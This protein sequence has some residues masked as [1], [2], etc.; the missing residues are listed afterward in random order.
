M[1]PK[2]DYSGSNPIL[3]SECFTFLVLNNPPL[4]ICFMC[5][6][7]PLKNRP[8]YYL[9]RITNLQFHSH[10]HWFAAEI[11]HPFHLSH[12]L[13]LTLKNPD[14]GDG[15]S[16]SEESY[17]KYDCC[18]KRLGEYSYHCSIC[19]Y[20][21][22]TTCTSVPL[23]LTIT[24]LKR[25]DHTLTLFPGHIP[26]PCKACG[27]SLGKIDDHVYTCHPCSYMVHKTCIYLPRVIKITRHAH[28][29]VHSSSLHSGELLCGVCRHT[30]D[31]SY[32][33]YS[34]T[35]KC[36]YAVHSKCAT[37][38]DVWDGKDL[39]EVPEEPDEDVAPFVMIDEKTIQHFSHEHWLKLHRNDK[40]NDHENKFCQACTLP[41]KISDG[42]Y[43]CMQ[44]DFV[45]DE[46]CAC[47]PRKNSHPVHKHPLT[48]LNIFPP[49]RSDLWFEMFPKGYFT[50]LGCG[51]E[52]C[53]FLYKCGEEDCT[54][55]LDVRCAY[56]PDPFIHGCHPHDHPLFFNLT[57]GNCM[58]CGND[59]CANYALECI[60]CKFFLGLYCATI[61][62]VAHYK[63]H[64]NPLTLCYGEEKTTVLQ[65]W[66]EVCESK[67]DSKT[68][69][70]ACG[71]CSLTL[72]IKCLLGAKS[73][74]KPN[75]H[76][77]TLRGEVEVTSNNGNSRP[78]CDQCD[79]R[80]ID[81][82]TY[83]LEDKYCCSVACVNISED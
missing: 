10:C 4:S 12:P 48:L 45:L 7:G 6:K 35:K 50:C 81:T 22:C 26:L 43:S 3:P 77:K 64:E 75:H 63:Y 15:V 19:D 72:H 20:S 29:L 2:Y 71:C 30:I 53:G 59:I 47:L 33:Q 14:S 62:S 49:K 31:V 78:L 25:H 17:E 27:T 24:H 16:V 28:R 74:M 76:I 83:K 70:Y 42:F 9:C 46:I 51:R 32:G 67:L 58:G 68:W 69:F 41:I 44:C 23:N 79:I 38:E 11:R 34:C 21:L 55:Q 65:Y 8:D 57:N 66:C 61:P 39:E 5:R 80:C 60:K 40:S 82:V 1:E 56:L 52:S 54:F 73:Y 36:H 37:R 18:R 13:T